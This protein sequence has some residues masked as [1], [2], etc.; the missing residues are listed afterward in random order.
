MNGPV[1]SGARMAVY[2]REDHAPAAGE[3]IEDDLLIRADKNPNSFGVQQ[4]FGAV[5]PAPQGDPR[6][7]DE[8]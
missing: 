2:A 6:G 8:P 1:P 7:N 5:R 4:R 3:V